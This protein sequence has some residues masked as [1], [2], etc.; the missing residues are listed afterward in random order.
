MPHLSPWY[1][2]RTNVPI[3]TR[4]A[5]SGVIVDIPI[6]S[7]AAQVNAMKLHHLAI[8]AQQG[9]PW[10]PWHSPSRDCNHQVKVVGCAAIP[11]TIVTTRKHYRSGAQLVDLGEFIHVLAALHHSRA[12]RCQSRNRSNMMA[13]SIVAPSSRSTR[14][15]LYR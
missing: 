3:C 11:F 5:L 8:W 13:H 12:L 14:H 6:V 9:Q 4:S 2:Q 7:F 10:L 1:S 15:L